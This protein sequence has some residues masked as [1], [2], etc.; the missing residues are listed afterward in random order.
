MRIR[1]VYP[2]SRVKKKIQDPESGWKDLSIFNPKMVSKLSEIWSGGFIP[3][4]DFLPIMDPR[5]RIQGSKSTGSQ[6]R[7]ATLHLKQG[8]VDELTKADAL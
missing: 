1:D 5:Y 7:T 8:T 6:I 3:D 2:G 4:P